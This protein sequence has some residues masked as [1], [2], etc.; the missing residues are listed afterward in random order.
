MYIPSA[1]LATG[2]FQ[3]TRDKI[4]EDCLLVSVINRRA[5]VSGQRSVTGIDKPVTAERIG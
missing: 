5:V 4:A 2:S 3:G 1:L